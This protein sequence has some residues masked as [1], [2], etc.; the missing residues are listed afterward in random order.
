[1]LSIVFMMTNKPSVVASIV[2]VLVAL[3]LVPLLF[4]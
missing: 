2:S 1:V 4:C 3:A